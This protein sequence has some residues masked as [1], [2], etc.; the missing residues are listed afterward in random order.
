[1]NQTENDVFD[2][3]LY[4]LSHEGEVGWEKFKDAIN[5][6]TN[7]QPRYRPSTYLRFIA[8]LGHFDYDP[9]NL[10]DVAIAPTALVET[11]V[12]NRYVLVGSR[13]P[14][15]IKEIN[16]CI[17]D[18][19]GKLRKK[20]DLLAPTALVLSD[21]TKAAF[22]EIECFGIHISRAFSAKLSKLLPIPGRSSFS[23]IEAPLQEAFNKFNINTFKFDKLN[24]PHLIDNGLYGVS[25]HGPDV[26]ILKSG[27][28]QRKVPR[29]WGV[30]LALSDAGKTTGL[31]CYDKETQIWQVKSPLQ[32]PLILDRCATLCSGFP[33]KLQNNLYHYSY[34]P[35][36]IAYQLTKSLHQK[37]EKFDV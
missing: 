17:S 3:L 2:N 34:V 31:V 16:T 10:S 33:P 6:L 24:N 12:P 28:D 11:S 21:L 9:S 15:F 25:Q 29:Y 1:M 4:Y 13:T 32:L 26:H 19:G 20:S 30:W 35:A 22:T 37:W 23:P 36:G 8:R 18:T 27:S 5:R 7:Y 14:D